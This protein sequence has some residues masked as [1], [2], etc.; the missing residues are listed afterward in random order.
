MQNNKN[1][2]IETEERQLKELA[3]NVRQNTE[4][5]EANFIGAFVT[6]A[7]FYLNRDAKRFISIVEAYASMEFKQSHHQHLYTFYKGL[8]YQKAGRYRH[9]IKVFDELIALG[10]LNTKLRARSL[11]SRAICQRMLAHYEAALDDYKQS[12][13]L[14]EALENQHYQGVVLINMGIVSYTLQMYREAE[15]YLTQALTIFKQSNEGQMQAVVHNEL[16]LLYRD[17]GQ[18]H[19]ALKS[20]RIYVDYR[21][22]EGSIDY[23]GHGL[24]NIGEVY[25]F[26]GQ[27]ELAQEAFLEA[28]T[29]MQIPA[30]R[31][32]TYLNLGFVSIVNNA[33]DEA[34]SYFTQALKLA[35][36]IDRRDILPGIHYRL[37]ETSRLLGNNIAALASLNESVRIIEETRSPLQDEGIK[38]S[39]LGRWQQI[40]ESQ[41]LLYLQMGNETAALQAVERA[42]SRAFLDMLLS[43]CTDSDQETPFTND[44]PMTATE[45]Q[46]CLPSGTALIE[47]FVTGLPGTNKGITENLPPGS[48]GLSAHLLPE[49][50]VLAF[51]ITDKHIQI[52]ELDVQVSQIQAQLFNKRDGRLRGMM[53]VP[54]KR[55]GAMRRWHDLGERLLAPLSPLVDDKR[56]LIFVPHGILHYLP[57]HAM[58]KPSRLTGTTNTTVS[59]APSASVLFN[60]ATAL[61]F[62]VASP[63]QQRGSDPK[64][65]S[66][67]VN[68][69]GLTHAEA[70]AAWIAESFGGD[71][72]IGQDVKARAVCEVM[73]NYNVLHFSCHGHFQ[74]RVPMDSSLQLA[75][76]EL[77]AADLLQSVQLKADLVT[78]SA[79]DTGLNELHPGD[80]LMG[81]TRAFLG[82]GTRS[83]LATLWP[84]HEIPTRIFMECFYE[85]WMAGASKAQALLAAQRLVA[86][87]DID[88]LSEQ[89]REY[90]ICQ[91]STTDMLDLFQS[92]AP[93]QGPFAHP[94]Y[95]AGFILI[96]AFD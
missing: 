17:L 31:V 58:T 28:S 84:I 7:E 93:G 57:L 67:G 5:A 76:G 25:L 70:E 59:Y 8:V 24:N 27:Y 48:D 62:A 20:L 63:M 42:R 90:G 78:L 43:G 75:D 18:W 4:E 21:R 69:D 29:I 83:L 6:V 89:L 80:E 22:M 49:E 23:V 9:S 41:A 37:G 51:V 61:A 72:L 77:T 86:H 53:P 26:S 15:T 60:R 19:D 94:Y 33:L 96:G 34:R 82:C 38:I 68:E 74:Q 81:L 16:G 12:F 40:Y 2:Y 46:A 85:S 79:C 3:D 95:W 54:G 87:M 14:W 10:E 44:E 39:L 13:A 71:C 73:P 66:L 91:G 35:T 32:D 1:A 92:M 55:L 56:H 65:L 88:A 64:I 36:E 50:K 11:N 47:F 30:Y 52:V 45:I